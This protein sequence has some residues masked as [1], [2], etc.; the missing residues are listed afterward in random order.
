[1][2]K[3]NDIKSAFVTGITIA[4]SLV[5]LFLISKS[6]ADGS[7]ATLRPPATTERTQTEIWAGQTQ[8]VTGALNNA[9]NPS[10]NQCGSLGQYNVVRSFSQNT[11]G[12]FTNVTYW[13][14]D[15]WLDVLIGTTS[16]TASD[17]VQNPPAY[18]LECWTNEPEIEWRDTP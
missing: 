14:F 18:N 15:T 11:S 16:H 12:V 5:G 3:N 6:Q 2:I 9:G 8:T 1:M 10:Q 4:F 7:S 17:W 13:E